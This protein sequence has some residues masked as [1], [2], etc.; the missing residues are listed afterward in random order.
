[1]Q[2]ERAE[3]EKDDGATIIKK[4]TERSIAGSQHLFLKLQ[5][6]EKFLL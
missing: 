4:V 2:E 1:M 5:L 3:R 6:M